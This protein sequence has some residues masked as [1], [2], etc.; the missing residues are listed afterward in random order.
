MKQYAAQLAAA[1]A[2]VD[3]LE[4]AVKLSAA[5]VA[6]NR[7]DSATAKAEKDAADRLQAIGS[8]AVRELRVFKLRRAYEAAEAAV[9][10][11][12]ASE[13]QAKFALVAGKAN[14]AS[15]Q[16]Q[17]D[18]AEFTLSQTI[19]KAP[20][21]GLVTN[22]QA[23][24]GTITTALRASA[25]G[26]FMEMSNARIIAVLPQ[27]LMRKVKVGDPVE[28]AFLSRPGKIDTGKVI[29]V[30]KYTGEG[31]LAPSGDLPVIADI[32]SKGFLAAT[33]KLDDE[34]LGQELSLGEAGAAAIYT[35]PAGPFHIVSKIY[36]R[37]LSIL[38]FLP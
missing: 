25:I 8:S 31:Q 23:R 21:D 16:G 3:R 14:I 6:R 30:N 11:S 34:A 15:I 22:W 18:N 35:Q 1:K 12:L 17:L 9:N 19:Y 20:S 13:E 36:L 27:N 4:A 38:S 2:E 5:T 33:I 37:M 32:G 29:R 10:E 28:L 24:V 26:T 7:A